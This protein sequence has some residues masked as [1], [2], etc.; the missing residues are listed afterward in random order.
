MYYQNINI[1]IILLYIS[2]TSLLLNQVSSVTTTITTT[3]D[4]K[5][6]ENLRIEY[7][8]TPVIGLTVRRPRFSWSLPS[9]STSQSD[10]GL[11]Q[12]AYHII[13]ENNLTGATIW[14]SGIVQS[15]DTIGI[16]FPN[17][18]KLYL[19][20]DQSYRFNVKWVDQQK[21][22]SP[23]ATG[24]FTTA[25][26]E[27][28][29]WGDAEW[30]TIPDTNDSRNQFRTTLNIPNNYIG[31]QRATCY[32][33]G[34]GYHRSFVNGIRL[35][36]PNNTL[37][38]SL[39]F[40]RKIP[41]ET[42]DV[43]NL[44][45]P[46][47][48]VLSI[49]LGRGWYTLP[50]DNFTRVLG[51]RTLGP[52]SLKVSCRAILN[53]GKQ[54]LLFTTGKSSTWR[55][56]AGELVFDHL[57]L[58]PTIDKRKA[59]IGWK[60]VDY[61]DSKWDVVVLQKNDDPT[62]IL[63]SYIMPKVQ[64]HQ[65]RFP[66]A[67]KRI[68]EQNTT[69][70]VLDFEF[71]QAMQ[72]TL[73]YHSDGTDEGVTLRLHHAEQVD[74]NGDIIISN[75]LG[76]VEDQTTFI[77]SN[78][79]GFQNFETKFSYFGAR[80]VKISGWPENKKEPGLDIMT[81]Y[82]V[83]TSLS[84]KSSIKFYSPETSSTANILNGIHE[85]TMRSALSNYMS[86]PTDCPSRE[87]RGWTG[88][89]QTAAETLIYSFDMSS[90]Y[91]K[92]LGD[93]VDAQQCNFRAPPRKC[94][95]ENP[96]C[97]IQGD[98]SNI[99]EMTPFLFGGVLD[100]CQSGSDPAWGSGFIAIVDWVYRYYGD[101]QTLK[102]HYSAGAAYL[103]YLLQYV[104]TTSSSLLDLNY[105]TTRY[106]DWCAPLPLG[107]TQARH[108]SNIINGFFWI[109]QLRIMTDAAKTLG[110]TKDEEKWSTLETHASKS[111]N[112]LYFSKKKGLY[113]DIECMNPTEK[114]IRPCHNSTIG[115]DGEMSKQTAQALP[116]F[117]DLPS[118]INDKVRV[119]N[120]LAEDVLNGIYPGRTTAGL[121][122]T[123][124]IL[125]ELVKSGHSDVAL[126][127]ATS[128]EYPS[129]GYMLPSSIHPAGQGEGTLWERWKGDK[130]TGFGSRNHIMLGGFD[131]PFFYGN[132]AGIQNDGIAWSNILIAPTV[133]GDL[134]GV[135][136]SV[137]TIRGLIS[138]KWN[139][140]EDAVG[141]FLINVTVPHG[142][143]GVIHLPILQEKNNNI[144]ANDVNV[145]EGGICFW[146]AK[147]GY[148]SESVPGIDMAKS[149]SNL[150]GKFIEVIIQSGT[151]EF[152]LTVVA[153][154]YLKI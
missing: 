14:D 113:E 87:K 12:T 93:I 89:G 54:L 149:G 146:K 139:V 26:M 111:F 106:G 22:I 130:H 19:E 127:I 77:L 48:N 134:S 7:V 76:G 10:R 144:T 50:E 116:L 110:F 42:Y 84:G 49:L 6:L 91:P 64:K 33:A 97:R 8:P 100:G 125:S 66:I 109:K 24:Y 137:A 140:L 15:K 38:Q 86:T 133:A 88:D 122:G 135:A 44:L 5:P 103:D 75:D 98:H 21:R 32:I 2:S 4:I 37:G 153:K 45:K 68:Q 35:G 131:G 30:I 72:C 94:P 99:P 129:W 141:K 124:Y 104:N 27:Q 17:N 11:F 126:K 29:D 82:F 23:M 9:S 138:V 73:R 28:S 39:Q 119:G 53:N 61:D 59:T 152:D 147:V 69:N 85:I 108:T 151:Y 81:C 92:W 83:H 102:W 70:F 95:D 43:L 40:Q 55:V 78:A 145:L 34:L 52:R 114:N 41:Y 74:V 154:D 128:V 46:G 123:K 62:G 71:N 3:E 101:T 80:F 60:T 112:E 105:P 142:T 118:S 148:I 79:T 107:N 47:K 63:T 56:S 121:V 150:A 115:A 51:Y 16:T 57:F 120:A 36:N 31:M 136:A 143:T 65:P 96:F 1:V 25:L 67:I 117:L 13:L 90:A 58:G 132:L 20:S 18:N